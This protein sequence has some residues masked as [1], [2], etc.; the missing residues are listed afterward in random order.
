GFDPGFNTG[1]EVVYDDGG[2]AD[3][4]GLT[5]GNVYYV[6]KDATNSHKIKLATTHDNAVNGTAITLTSTGGHAQQS[7]RKVTS[8]GHTFDGRTNVL[9]ESAVNTIT[10]PSNSTLQTGDAVVYHSGDGTGIPGLVD[11]QTYYV[12][13]KS[14]T[15]IELATA[16]DTST[17]VALPS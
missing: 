4:G 9:S 15:R 13:R 16:D 3:I 8:S 17:P 1:D 5:S 6:I 14:T 7:F 2:G 12:I 11:G 10:V